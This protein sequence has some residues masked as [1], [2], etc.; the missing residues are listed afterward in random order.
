MLF[1]GVTATWTDFID[2][3][4]ADGTSA[5]CINAGRM[6]S[7]SGSGY[8]LNNRPSGGNSVTLWRIDNALTTPALT[9]VATVSVG[10]YTPPPDARQPGKGSPYIATGD[11]RLQNVVMQDGFLHTAFSMKYG[12]GKIKPGAGIR[13]LKIS[14]AGLVATN[15]SSFTSAVDQYY[16]SVTVDGSGNMFVVFSRSSA[17]EYAS[18]YKTGMMTT[19]TAIE[20]GTLVK[21]GQ[22]LVTNGRWGEYNGIH[23]DPSNSGAVW[24]YSGWEASNSTW[25]SY[26][27]ATSFG[28]PPVTQ[29]APNSQE[30]TIHSFAL[31]ANYPNPFN[32]STLISYT[33][34]EEAHAK[35]IVYDALGRQVATLA[36]DV[37]AAGAHQ[38]TFNAAGLSSGVYFY[39]L[40]AGKNIN[41][42][43]MLL[44]K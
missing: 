31:N 39:R 14:T 26:V 29:S 6:L 5:S 25:G 32:P 22:G 35:L 15:V 43:K 37:Q 8:L 28:A 18:M 12:G 20:A 2:L 21:A 4:N 3:R 10:A 42:N 36:D 41:I 16:P 19:E 11:C 40:E 23:N 34:P 9:L 33:L 7:S 24:M 44:A 13:Y 17:T 1:S 38:V 30:G 27:A